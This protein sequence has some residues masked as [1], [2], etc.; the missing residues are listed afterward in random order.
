LGGTQDNGSSATSFA[1]TSTSWVNVNGGDGG[2]NAIDPGAT[3]NWYV[4]NPDIAPGGLN[5]SGVFERLNCRQNNFNVVRGQQ[6]RG[7]MTAH[8]MFLTSS[9]RSRRREMLVGTCRVWRGPRL[10]ALI[11]C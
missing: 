8:S 9:I 2:Y 11:P 6:Q 5:G 10:G 7:E 3:S 4:S 1:T